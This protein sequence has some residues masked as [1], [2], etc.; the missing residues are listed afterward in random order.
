MV[1]Y[2]I[3]VLVLILFMSVAVNFVFGE[4][5]IKIVLLHTNDIHG[6][7]TPYEDAKIAPVPEKIGG[8]EYL[9]TLI[10][11]E[12]A[13]N[14][15][16]L[17]LDGGDIAQGSL[18]SNLAY[19]I[20]VIELMNNAG[21]DCSALGNHDFDWGAEKLSGMINAARFPVIAANV[22][23][24][25]SGNF[26]P[27]TEPYILKDI[28]GIRLGIIGIAC[29]DTTVLSPECSKEKYNFLSAEET[30]K[31]YIPVLKEIHKADL[32]IVISHL[33]YKE[34]VEL[35]G[36]ISGIDVIIGAH[37]HKAIEAPVM[38]NNTI[39]VQAGSYLTY[40][41]KTELQVH[42]ETKKII[43]YSGEL[44]KILNSQIKPDIEVKTLLD[45]Y[46]EKYKSFGEK[47]IGEA[48]VDLTKSNVKECNLGNLVADIMRFTGESDIALINTGGLREDIPAGHVTIEK[49]YGVYPFENML[50]SM[51]LKGKYIKEIIET[52]FNGSHAILQV[53]GLKIKYDFSKPGSDKVVEIL[54][55]NQPLEDEKTYRVTTADFLATGGDGYESFKKGEN[56]QNIMPIRDSIIKYFQE[57]SPVS[58][59]IEGRLENVEKK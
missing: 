40:L 45:K 10:K 8:F 52:T 18:Y 16:A 25:K 31:Y 22:I 58:G 14:P 53:S 54:V 7:I 15:G 36:K 39:I 20:P 9:S 21:Y 2:K 42:K 5:T 29:T 19:G 26:I 50:V 59:E 55:N 24:R 1:T 46:R 6:H 41:G 4:E 30:L 47:I 38:K 3:P 56:L 49:I 44:I 43:G 57:H 51:D 32:I 13:K 27:G 28:N 33:G 23:E 35:C 11:E 37:S 17:L 34:D 48:S 12:R